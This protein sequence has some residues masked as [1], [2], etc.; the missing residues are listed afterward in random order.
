GLTGVNT[1]FLLTSSFTMAWA[2]AA[3]RKSDARGVLRWLLITIGLGGLFLAIQIYEYVEITGVFSSAFGGRPFSGH[4]FASTFFLLTG[5]HAAHVLVGL[6]YL[7]CLVLPSA[8]GEYTAKDHIVLD[9]AALFWHF[10]DWVW[11]AIFTSLYIL[12]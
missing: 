12:N 5:F 6:I 8:R 9:I 2:V 11:V 7:S 10:V 1:V 3:A 4:L